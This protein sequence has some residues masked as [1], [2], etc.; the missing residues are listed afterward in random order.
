MARQR[1][2]PVPG[3]ESTDAWSFIV[4][5]ESHQGLFTVKEL[6]QLVGKSPCTL[7]RGAAARR[8]PSVRVLGGVMFDPAALGMHFRKQSPASASAAR[9]VQARATE[10]GATGDVASDSQNG[11]RLASERHTEQ[12]N[13]EGA[14]QHD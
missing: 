9:A 10:K 13:P 12:Q 2:L 6:A 4:A 5:I 8:L 14:K 3:T 11:T 7:Y 1:K